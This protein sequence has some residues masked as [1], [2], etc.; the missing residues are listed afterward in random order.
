MW[1]I[2]EATCDEVAVCSRCL[3]GFANFWFFQKPGT[4]FF[5]RLLGKSKSFVEKRPK[6]RR[7]MAQRISM[8]PKIV[9]IQIG[10][11]RSS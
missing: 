4:L 1:Q 7:G 3:P 10:I 11:S 2:E 8:V 6:M 5:P 9:E